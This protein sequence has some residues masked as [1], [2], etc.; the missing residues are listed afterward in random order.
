MSRG[1]T[2]LAFAWSRQRWMTSS[3]PIPARGLAA[4]SS[5]A[6]ARRVS[7]PQFTGE[8]RDERRARPRR[9]LL[10]GVACADL[11]DEHAAPRP[12]KRLEDTAIAGVRV[13][14]VA[15]ARGLA[16]PVLPDL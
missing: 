16:G 5:P 4:R 1:S 14:F 8:G 9:R 12:S 11:G 13:L 7:L 10:D 3:S 6:A 15:P 2:S